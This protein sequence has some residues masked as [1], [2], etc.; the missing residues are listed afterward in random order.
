ME[1]LLAND[2]P[3]VDT[4]FFYKIHIKLNSTMTWAQ[5]L[6]LYYHIYSKKSYILLAN[7]SY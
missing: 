6:N 7:N 4:I 2:G 3:L 1:H 5:L